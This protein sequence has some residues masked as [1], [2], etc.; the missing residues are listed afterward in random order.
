MMKRRVRLIPY[1]RGSKSCKALAEAIGAKQIKIDGTSRFRNTERDFLINWGSTTMLPNIDYRFVLNHPQAIEQVSNKLTFFQS[2]SAEGF[3]QLVPPFY[4]NKEDI[5]D[6]SFPIVCRT[7]LNAH[8]GRGIV[9]ADSRDGL[10]DAPLYTQYIKKQDEYRIHF[11]YPFRGDGQESIIL[12]TQQKKRRLDHANPDW[13]VRNHENGFVYAREGVEVPWQ[14]V[15][16]AKTIFDKCTALDFGA[17]DVIYNAKQERA[18]VLEINSAPGLEGQT[19]E[20]YANHY[21]AM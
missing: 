3:E 17:V 1:R 12:A 4:T 13:R 19:L 8:S 5:P 7:L 16:A 20:D 21:G 18:Y 14:A 15:G 6:E 9:I 11:A 10:V 2:I